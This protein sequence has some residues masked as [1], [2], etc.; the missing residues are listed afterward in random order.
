MRMSAVPLLR[1][2]RTRSPFLRSARRPPAAASG[3]ALRID[4]DPELPDW[5]PSPTPRSQCTPFLR[6]S[7]SA[8]RRD[9]AGMVIVLAQ[10][11]AGGLQ[12]DEERHVVSAFFPVEDIELDADMAGDGVEMDGAI[13]RAADRRIDGDGILEGFA[14]E[15]LRGG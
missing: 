8:R 9:A 14:G 5:R 1:S 10:I 12:I 7:L 15:N 13:G 4:G 2:M 11:L 3:D 6:R